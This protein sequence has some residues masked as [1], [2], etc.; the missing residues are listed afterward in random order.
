MR[1]LLKDSAEGYK[2]VEGE[3]FTRDQQFR[4]WALTPDG[5]VVYSEWKAQRGDISGMMDL[6][7]G[8]MH[9]KAALRFY[10]RATSQMRRREFETAM[11]QDAANHPECCMAAVNSVSEGLRKYLAERK[12][13]LNAAQVDD[14]ADKCVKTRCY[15]NTGSGRL[16]TESGRDALGE[17]AAL[18]KALQTLH[19]NDIAKILGIQVAFANTLSKTLGF[20]DAQG[21]LHKHTGIQVAP[22]QGYLYSWFDTKQG[23]D[24]DNFLRG[25]QRT[26]GAVPTK[27]PG[28]MP[29]DGADSAEARKRGIDEWKKVDDSSFVKGI[30]LR[31]L[32]F[33][34]GR[35]GTTGELLKTYRVFGGADSEEP[36]KQYLLAIVVYLIGGGHHTCHEI[37]SVANLL[38]GSN[39]PRGN[40]PYASVATLASDAYVPG[41][42]LKHLPSSYTSTM[43]FKALAEKYYDIAHMGHLH[44]TFV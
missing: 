42:Y 38:V 33:G 39:G 27:A 21:K 23:T 24:K 14:E 6:V 18:A 7:L 10:D 17:G 19:G 36:F 25:R 40:R 11:A 9:G 1:Y 5:R 37:F 32:I 13:T 15:S 30:D 44:G 4:P 20:E 34:A 41:K 35:S 28:L 22:S 43:H 3:P 12:L 29:T 26:Q 31:N 8:K 16:G 2:E